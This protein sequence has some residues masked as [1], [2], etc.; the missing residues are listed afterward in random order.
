M[1]H[2]KQKGLTAISLLF[3]LA[4]VGGAIY[5]ALRVV[6]M[7]LNYYK[8][9]SVLESI[10]EDRETADLGKYKIR[11]LISRRFNINYVEHIDAKDV[12]IKKTQ[13]GMVM[14][15]EYEERAPLFSN[16]S[17]V[18]SFDKSVEVTR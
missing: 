1:N 13:K 5:T 16:L 6:P 10:K 9:V 14:S 8:V 7:Y 15:V 12:K 2:H 4:L 18:A 17:V 3:V 11:D